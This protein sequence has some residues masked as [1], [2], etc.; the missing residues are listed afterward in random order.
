M[1]RPL[2]GVVVALPGTTTMALADSVEDFYKA[3]QVKLIIGANTGGSYDS[4]GR[5]LAAN[6]GR[7][8]RLDSRTGK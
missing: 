5:L 7:Q 2:L 8:A 1:R 6:L 4:Y 3:R